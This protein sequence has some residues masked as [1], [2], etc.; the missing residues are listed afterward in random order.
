MKTISILGSTGSIGTQVLDIVS[1]LPERL[2]VVGLAAHRNVEL[3]AE[4]V[5]KYRPSLVSIGTEENAARLREILKRTSNLERPTSYPDIVW[6]QEGLTR[7]AA[8]P[9]AQTAVISVAG[10]IGLA[11][12]IEA[13]KA[14][15]E[16]AL[17]SKEVLVAAGSLVTKLVEEHGVRMLPI[18]S[19][20]SALFQCL[21]GEDP[22]SVR[23]LI[24]TAS[25]GAFRDHPVEALRTAT[26][27]QALAHPNW[28]MGR[29]ITIDSATLMNKCLEI[30]E[31]RWLFGVDAERIEV[32]IHPQ[33]IVHSMV[34]FEDASVIAQLGVPDMRLPIQYALLYPERPDTG[35][36]RLDITACGRLDF[37]EP[38][39][40]RYP[41][42]SLAYE[43][44]ERGG[45]MPAVMNAA[46]E[47][48]VGLFLEKAIGFLDIC[49]LTRKTMESHS[50]VQ[51]PTLDQIIEADAWARREAAAAAEDCIA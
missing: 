11:P 10:A 9:E 8:M 16:I 31:A 39:L 42:L 37:R 24:L 32:V 50:V 21:D 45:T 23:R 36:P 33:S 34:E 14:G 19:E 43:A 27:E 38:D 51:E 20:H 25:G 13:I 46:N 22:K 28:T 29:K 35:L 12:T 18:D 30:I 44:L 48:A 26:I 41:A 6:G 5:R 2:K 49:G 40:E 47:A 4:Q 1:R 15:K 7:V 17:A 3:L